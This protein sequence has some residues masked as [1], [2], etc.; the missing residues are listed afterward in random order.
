M[1]HLARRTEFLE[2][3]DVTLRDNQ[4][5]NQEASR[6]SEETKAWALYFQGGEDEKM[7]GILANWG[8]L[9]RE[10]QVARDYEYAH[11]LQNHATDSEGEDNIDA[12]YEGDTHG[13]N[14]DDT[15]TEHESGTNAKD[16]TNAD[17]K[18]EDE[19]AV[20]NGSE[21]VLQSHRDVDRRF[22]SARFGSALKDMRDLHA[23]LSARRRQRE[24]QN[25]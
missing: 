10:I 24:T 20:E 2:L 14:G 8:I 25:I 22:A 9:R 13:D 11:H 4:G 6:A 12:D 21:D 15:C 5:G 19:N 3:N 23:S 16:K 18:D 17:N 7:E 1:D